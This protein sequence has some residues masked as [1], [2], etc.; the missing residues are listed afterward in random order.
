MKKILDMY[1]VPNTLSQFLS[2]ASDYKI[3]TFYKLAR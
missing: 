3:P 2:N 1:K